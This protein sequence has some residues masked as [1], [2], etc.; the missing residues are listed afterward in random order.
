[1]RQ[2]DTRALHM[3]VAVAL[4]LN[5]RQAAEQLHMTQPP[6]SRAI[7]ALERRLGVRLFERDTHSVALTPAAAQL[8]PM[9][10]HILALLDAAERALTRQPGAAPLRL[11]L[12]SAVEPDLFRPFTAALGAAL[13]AGALEL[14]FEPS[15]QLVAA[16]RASRLDAA[17][18]AL[19]SKTAGL[20]LHPLG[21]QALM[22]A[23][24]SGHVLTRRR[25]LTLADL[26]DEPVFWFERARQ[27]AYFDHCHAV[28]KRHGFAPRFVREAR[29]HHVLLSDIA[30]GKG[31]ALLPE[32]FRALRRTGVCYRTLAEG[33]ELALAIGLITAATGHPALPALQQLALDKLGE[34]A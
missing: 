4:C 25:T 23:L 31:V 13:G 29:D 10:Q 24:Q 2:L 6:L 26:R 5:F 14:S 8:L 19:P 7:K 34:P 27:P 28:F 17:L 30:A 12:T 32:S 16:V 22:V 33:S 20:P 15:P 9:A 11:G 18:I 21:R 3:F 1:M